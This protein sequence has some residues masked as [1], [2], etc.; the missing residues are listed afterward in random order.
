MRPSL[1]VVPRISPRRFRILSHISPKSQYQINNNRGTHCYQGC[2]YKILADAAGSNTHTVA[3]S[4]TNAKGI[5][6]NKAFEFVHTANLKNLYQTE[7]L[8]PE[9]SLFYLKFATI[10]NVRI[11]SI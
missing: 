1:Q 2:V 10:K 5:P 3:D 6:F 7:R 8:N 11:R 4:G 9:K